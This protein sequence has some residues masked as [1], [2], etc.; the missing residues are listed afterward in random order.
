MK[1][2]KKCRQP[3]CRDGADVRLIEDRIRWGAA[4][5]SFFGDNGYSLRPY[6]CCKGCRAKLKQGGWRYHR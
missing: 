2:D 1:T 3:Q 5:K 6:P 4:V